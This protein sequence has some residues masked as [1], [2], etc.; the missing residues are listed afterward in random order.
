MMK[1]S[2]GSDLVPEEGSGL[3]L[4]NLFVEGD[5]FVPAAGLSISAADAGCTAL[6]D[7]SVAAGPLVAGTKDTADNG[8]IISCALDGLATAAAVEI[9]GRYEA[10]P[11]LL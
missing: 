2:I 8:R 3:L 4:S 10:S 7:D 1:S 9:A 6:A 5:A 11:L